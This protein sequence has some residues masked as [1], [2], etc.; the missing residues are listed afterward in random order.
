M[1]FS[2]SNQQ[3][4]LAE[5]VVLNDIQNNFSSYEAILSIKRWKFIIRIPGIAQHII[6]EADE[7]I[8]KNFL[9]YITSEQVLTT[10]EFHYPDI[11]N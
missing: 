5:L 1:D 6:K 4:S 7:N 8:Q 2:I 10:E 9:S 3:E 11:C